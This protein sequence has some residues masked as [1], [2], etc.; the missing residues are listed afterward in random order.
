MNDLKFA[1]RQLLKNPGFTAVAVLTL[2]LGI[3][4]RALVP[5]LPPPGVQTM[6]ALISEAV[7]Q[8]RLQTGLLGLFGLLA[9]WLTARRAA[10]V[11]PIC[12]QLHP[13]LRVGDLPTALAFYTSKPGFRRG[14]HW[15]DPPEM[16]GV[17]LGGVSVHLEEQEPSWLILLFLIRN[18]LHPALCWVRHA[19]WPDAD[20]LRHSDRCQ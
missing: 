5:S 10:K 18:D 1:F 13:L 3:G 11:D 2:A 12:G 8:P 17:N 16:A 19:P 7:A 20:S 14:F 15:G 4:A 6:N 9:C